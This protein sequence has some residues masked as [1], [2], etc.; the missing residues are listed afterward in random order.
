MLARAIYAT[1]T[2]LSITENRHWIN[3]LHKIRPSLKLPSRHQLSNTLLNNEYDRVKKSVNEKIHNAK[4]IGIQIDGWSNIRNESIVNV[5]LTTPEPVLYKIVDT[6]AARHE[7]TFICDIISE[8][9]DQLGLEKIMSIITDNARNMTASWN[10]LTEKYPNS[11]F[12]CYGCAAHILN[13]LIH[14]I[15]KIKTYDSIAVKSKLIIKTIKKSHILNATL[16]SIQKKNFTNK[17]EIKTLKLPVIT[18]WGSI[19]TSLNSLLYNK[20]NLQELSISENVT[21]EIA[22]IKV[23]ILDD[24]VWLRIE[25]LH[26]I[27]SPLAKYI[28]EIQTSKPI[29]SRVVEIFYNMY[30]HF[31]NLLNIKECDRNELLQLLEK[32]KTMAVG[33]LHFAANLLDPYFMG[34]NLNESEYIDALTFINKMATFLTT[35]NELGTVMM[36][37]AF[38]K[39]KEGLF[40]KDFVWSSLKN[41]KLSAV[42][43]WKSICATTKLSKVAVEILNCPPST[44]ATE[45]S[46]S[47][48]GNVHT[49]KRNRLTN[50]RAQ[51]IVY[52]R[53]NLNITEQASGSSQYFL[54]SENEYDWSETDGET[55][56]DQIVDPEISCSPQST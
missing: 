29:I 7:A 44:A 14:D 22:N 25:S 53:Q 49:N 21:N 16:S 9:I 26:E 43:W 20:K 52:V 32:R 45:R 12:S 42:T 46:F 11:M 13:L 35:E 5:L 39:S 47:T 24:E 2:P 37:I 51:K 8:T 1:N 23:N 41:G 31:S 40:G 50:E 4:T 17:R 27:L 15:L 38:Y 36:E 6:T 28:T 48:Y 18:R 10:L 33:P 30:S 54:E 19:Y 55:D 34:K 56:Q 3:V